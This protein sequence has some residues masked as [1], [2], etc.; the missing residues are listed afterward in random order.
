MTSFF[1]SSV[2]EDDA[3]LLAGA[4]PSETWSVRSY[5][6]KRYRDLI[7]KQLDHLLEFMGEYML[8]YISERKATDAVSKDIV[9]GWDESWPDIEA[10]LRWKLRIKLGVPEL[11]SQK[12]VRSLRLRYWQTE[13]P[14]LWPPGKCLP[15]PFIALRARVL[16]A[17]DPADQPPY[18]LVPTVLMIANCTAIL[19]LCNWAM[20]LRFLL[21]DK[22]DEYQLI[23]YI[24]ANKGYHFIVY[25]VIQRKQPR[26]RT[27]AH[28][29]GAKL[30]PHGWAGP[31]LPI[32]QALFV[33]SALPWPGRSARSAHTREPRRFH[34][35]SEL[36]RLLQLRAERLRS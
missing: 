1:R 33:G 31:S 11:A 28:G 24:L 29:D 22:S 3:A 32:D 35:R 20:L 6:V 23:S 2:S 7:D 15:Q 34:S 13:G 16:Y 17:I 10:D 26:A 36:V 8:S 4:E 21:M 25:G 12:L 18:W 5:G 30:L 14:A 19:E 27:P 9:E